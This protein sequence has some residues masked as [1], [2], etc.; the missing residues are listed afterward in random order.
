[1]ERV[2]AAM[3]FRLSSKYHVYVSQSETW[4]GPAVRK[5]AFLAIAVEIWPKKDGTEL[6][7][8]YM[9]GSTTLGCLLS[10]LLIPIIFF[11]RLSRSSARYEL[12]AEV[13]EAIRERWPDIEERD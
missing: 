2:L 6:V 3:K 1:M 4:S 11:V 12:E 8:G 9:P 7:T 13:I 5:G 10:L